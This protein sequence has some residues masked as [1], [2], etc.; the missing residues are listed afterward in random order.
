VFQLILVSVFK[1]PL[2]FF[3]KSLVPEWTMDKEGRASLVQ[4]MSVQCILWP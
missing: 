2:W 1:N 4:T 3:A